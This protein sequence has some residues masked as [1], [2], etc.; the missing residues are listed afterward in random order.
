MKF[1]RIKGTHEALGNMPGT[2]QEPAE[3]QPPS[4]YGTCPPGALRGEACF[5]ETGVLER[6]ALCYFPAPVKWEDDRRQMEQDAN[7][8]HS[9]YRLLL[10][11]SEPQLPHQIHGV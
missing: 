5:S 11:F 6:G 7:G 3:R 8:S 2:Q 1:T 10:M 4:R 9:T